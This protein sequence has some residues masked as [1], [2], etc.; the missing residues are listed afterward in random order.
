MNELQKYVDT[1]ADRCTLYTKFYEKKK[2]K[3]NQTFKY[4]IIKT[5]SF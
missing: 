2:E 1:I 4:T 5:F 3:E